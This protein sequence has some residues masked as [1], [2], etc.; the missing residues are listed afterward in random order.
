MPK[1]R[2]T[3]TFADCEYERLTD[4]QMALLGEDILKDMYK[5]MEKIER[6]LDIET[7][8][9]RNYKED[10]HRAIVAAENR[11]HDHKFTPEWEPQRTCKNWFEGKPSTGSLM[12]QRHYTGG[13]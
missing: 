12:G 5:D 9:A 1:T 8:S 13:F 6:R 4:E 7:I 2:K 10:I 11:S 3:V